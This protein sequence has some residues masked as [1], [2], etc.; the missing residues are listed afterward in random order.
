M[1]LLPCVLLSVV[2]LLASLALSEQ[3][4]RAVDVFEEALGRGPGP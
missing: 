4:F 2:S 3:V 1:K